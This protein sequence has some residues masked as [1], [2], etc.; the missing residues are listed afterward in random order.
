MSGPFPKPARL[1]RADRVTYS[2]AKAIPSARKPFKLA[3]ARTAL[4]RSF[5][6]ETWLGRD[7]VMAGAY[8]LNAELGAE[9]Q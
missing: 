5:Y 9:E 6:P 1:L 8:Y 3:S 2:H 4:W 7:I